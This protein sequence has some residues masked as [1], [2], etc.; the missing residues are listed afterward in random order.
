MRG[1]W[2]LIAQSHWPYWVAGIY[3]KRR[4]YDWE[5]FRALALEGLKQVRA[6]YR[7][8]R[9]VV[10]TTAF[11]P[12]ELVYGLG[13]VPFSVE[14]AAALATRL[15]LSPRLLAAA[16]RG[17]YSSDL[18]SF[19]RV[20]IGGALLDVWP[21]PAALVASTHLCDGAPRLF[22]NVAE[23]YGV[24]LWILDVPAQPSLEAE[25]Y[26]ADQ[27]RSL[28]RSLAS[29]A[30]GEAREGLRR[31]ITLSN[32]ARYWLLEVNRW[33]TALSSPL[34]GEQALDLLWMGFMGQGSGAA[35]RVY[36][37]L[38]EELRTRVSSEQK[39]RSGHRYRLLWLHLKPYYPVDFWD[40]VASEGAM[41]AFEEFNY[42]YWPALS[43]GEDLW[44]SLARKMLSHFSLGPV[45]RRVEVVR[46]LVR[47]YS[48]DGVVHFSHWGCRVSNGGARI[49]KEALQAK[50]VPYLLLPGD[51]LDRSHYSK[52]QVETRLAAFLELLGA[53]GS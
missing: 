8:E 35:V 37:R 21:R 45:E 36:R 16:D 10:W 33:R 48:C 28:F 1:L 49:L 9:P 24:P 41:V 38:A 26:L 3:L 4:P 23:L 34:R 32:E 22:H 46:K 6:W 25:L 31:S 14:V 2:R 43:A 40:L 15:G 42:V 20:A 19:H 12:T 30:E 27:L 11:V 47:E 51:C 39:R 7:N 29:L 13:L 17:W 5:A 18:C 52:G 44:V 50:G 53:R